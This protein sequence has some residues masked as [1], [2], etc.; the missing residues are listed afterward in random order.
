MPNVQPELISVSIVSH[1][2]GG[3]VAALLGDL[4]IHCTG[5]PIEVLLTL[6]LPE[7][8]PCDLSQFPFPVLRIDNLHP[9]GFGANHNQAFARSS[10]D[11]FS[12]LN[13][14]IRLSHDPFPALRAALND[15]LVGLSAPLVLNPSGLPEDSAR[16]FPSPLM[17]LLKALRLGRGRPYAVGEQTLHPD[18]VAGMCILLPAARFRQFGGFDTRYFLYYEDVDLCARLRLAGLQVALTPAARVTHAAQRASHRKLRYLVLHLR[19]ISRFF[20]SP[21]YWRVRLAR[22]PGQ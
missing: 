2:Q 22:E 11:F 3:L 6:N 12:V 20:C 7:D 15:P 10:G 21:V 5:T 16:P 19:S 8:L 13:P 4:A 14:D 1:G 17:I 9:L 18:W